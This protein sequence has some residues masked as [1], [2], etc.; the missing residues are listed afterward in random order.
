MN[1]DSM[2]IAN[3]EHGLS[4]GGAPGGGLVTPPEMMA[5]S[6]IDHV[7]DTSKNTHNSTLSGINRRIGGGNM[8]SSYQTSQ[9]QQNQEASR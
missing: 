1:D 3:Q 2:L 9:H 5:L 8:S 6:K 7:H 4:S